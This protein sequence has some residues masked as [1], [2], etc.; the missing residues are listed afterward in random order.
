MKKI[1]IHKTKIWKFYWITKNWKKNNFNFNSKLFK[2]TITNI[3]T[4][5][6]WSTF[7]RTNYFRYNRLEIAQ[8][9]INI[10]LNIKPTD[11][12]FNKTFNNNIIFKTDEA[13]DDETMNDEA[14][15]DEDLDGLNGEPTM[16]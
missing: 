8:S 2:C 4:F 7:I 10:Q 15:D 11:E 1:F 6:R 5:N 9:C 3:I 14:M 16:H 12:K 13:M